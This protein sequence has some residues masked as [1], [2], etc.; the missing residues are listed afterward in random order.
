MTEAKSTR[1]VRRGRIFPSIQWTEEQKAK[2]RAERENFH[3][4]SQVIFERIKPEYIQT[5]YNWY[6]VVE[7]ESGNYFIDLDEEVAMLLARQKHPGTVPLFLFRMN[8][9]GVSGTI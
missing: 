5:H 6:V 3:Q 7:P 2:R 9:T 1:T 8:E 4:R